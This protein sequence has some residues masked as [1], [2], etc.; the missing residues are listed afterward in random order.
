MQQ[1]KDREGEQESLIVW[2]DLFFV[3][4]LQ[5]VYAAIQRIKLKG[6]RLL[7]TNT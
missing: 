3:E 4:E 6:I 7:M 1:I 2:E 5:A